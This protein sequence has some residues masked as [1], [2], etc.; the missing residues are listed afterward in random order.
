MCFSYGSNIDDTIRETRKTTFEK[1]TRQDDNGNNEAENERFLVG[2]M[3]SLSCL[4]FTNYLRLDQRLAAIKMASHFAEPVVGNP[5]YDNSKAVKV[6]GL[7]FKP[8]AIS[9]IEL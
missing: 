1:S 5:V 4:D 7:T 3:D 9:I 2:G 6:L 8:P